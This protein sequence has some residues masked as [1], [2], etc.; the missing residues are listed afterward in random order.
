MRRLLPLLAFLTLLTSALGADPLKVGDEAPAFTL[1]NQYA[2][3]VSLKD[4]RDRRWVV[5]VL[6]RS[7]SCPYSMRQLKQLHESHRALSLVGT[8]PIVILRDDKKGAEG[9]KAALRKA[10][11]DFPLLDGGGSKELAS[12]GEMSFHSFIVSPDGRIKKILRGT[13]RTRPT[14]KQI[15]AELKKLRE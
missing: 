1:K 6:A 2:K 11:V 5:V 3:P 4:Y 12:Y 15:L 8:E 13:N 14:A 10:K 9:I 7:S